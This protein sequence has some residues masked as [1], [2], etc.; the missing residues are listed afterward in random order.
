MTARKAISSTQTTTLTAHERTSI[1]A[2]ER[3]RPFCGDDCVNSSKALSQ[4]TPCNQHTQPLD[5]APRTKVYREVAIR[6]TFL[7]GS[8]ANA[9][10]FSS[11][12]LGLVWV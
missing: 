5:A 3:E 2:R 4:K 11:S 6:L 7:R 10:A 8:A 9:C 12:K 1:R